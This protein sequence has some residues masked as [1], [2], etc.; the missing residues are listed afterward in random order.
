MPTAPASGYSEWVESGNLD[1][2]SYSGVV[3]IGFR[4]NAAQDANYATWCV[5]NIKLN[6]K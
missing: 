2:S 1:L 5:D 3:Y 4:Y 6:V